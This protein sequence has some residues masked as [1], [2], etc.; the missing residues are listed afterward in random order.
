MQRS[1]CAPIR[2]GILRN[3]RRLAILFA[4]STVAACG[5]GSP[6]PPVVT[7]PSTPVTVTGTERIGWDQPAADAVELAT[8]GY[9]IYVDGTRSVASGVAC[10]P[11]AGATAFACTAPLPPLTP[12]AHSLQVASF[13]DDGGLLESTR[14]AALQVTLVT[15]IA[16]HAAD[17]FAPRRA[18][19]APRTPTAPRS[20]PSS[21]FARAAVDT[22]GERQSDL[23]SDGL[24]EPID[25]ALAPDGRLFVAE[26]A[27]TVVVI[28]GAARTRESITDGGSQL[29]A[30]AIDPD[31]ARTHFV[32]AIYTE[33]DRGNAS[34]FA[35]ARFREAGGTLADRAVLV[36]SVPAAASARAALRFG[37][38]RRLY[39][40][41]D[42]GG[43]AR[44][45]ADSAS[46]SGK[47]L[48][49]NADG[50]TPNDSRALSPVIAIDV[51]APVGLA[52][53]RGAHNAWVV[54]RLGGGA[55]QL[56]ETGD[57]GHAYRL[58]DGFTPSSV[59]AAGDERPGDLLIGSAESGTLLRV[60]FDAATFQ[61]T[62]TEAVAIANVDRVRALAVAPDGTTYVA[63]ATSVWRIR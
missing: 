52:W 1:L 26:L 36:D 27:G 24:V 22:A 46:F 33:G 63:A 59:A 13:V 38:D 45:A 54:D 48:R 16:D 32:F 20:E 7:P 62:G 31:F 25:L 49:L 47:V 30:L 61:P 34:S 60:R 41:F 29:L 12:G 53:P 50:T 43:N 58:P 11:T 40:A 57:N 44:R 37:A 51:A 15:T 9:A 6:S 56:R 28:D 3:V 18:G 23:V 17:P 19:D 21:A 10:A 14:S 2:E 5:G 42:G 39:A 55:A 4:S 8:F 35:L